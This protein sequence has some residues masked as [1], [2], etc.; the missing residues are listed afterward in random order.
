MDL[1]LRDILTPGERKAA[2]RL[3]AGQGL[4]M[5]EG[6]EYGVAI[7]AGER[8]VGAGFRGKSTLMGLCVEPDRQGEGAALRIV[9]RLIKEAAEH[10]LTRLCVFTTPKEAPTFTAM[11]FRLVASAPEGAALLEWGFPSCEDWLAGVTPDPAPPGPIGTVVLNANPFTLG[12]LHLLEAAVARCATLYAL[13]VE[14]DASAFPFA[15][16]LRLVQEGMAHTPACRVLPGGP[17][18]ISS[19]TFPSY[20]SGTERHAAT[21]AALD[22][23]LFGQRIAPA[24]GISRRFVGTEPF[25]GV[26]ATYNAAMHDI[27]PAYGLAVFELPRLEAKDGA[28][29]AS[30][31]RAALCAGDMD[32]ALRYAPPV[33]AA[34][35]QSDEGGRIIA[36][37]KRH[38]V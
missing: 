21:H 3:L 23:H 2:R 7:W 18:V 6:V 29:S 14:E 34:F 5:P 38:S 10:G 36:A 25:S 15:A 11:G 1:V 4:D 13:V 35:L 31:L 19:R 37:L 20:F 24:L 26:T 12:H 30:R 28:I 9:D 27:L 22:L 32:K 16:R 8:L 33:T 17:Y